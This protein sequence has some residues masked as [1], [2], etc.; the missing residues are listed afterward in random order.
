MGQLDD[1]SLLVELM[2]CRLFKQTTIEVIPWMSNYILKN[3]CYYL[4]MP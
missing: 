3:G 4:S 2:A 1:K